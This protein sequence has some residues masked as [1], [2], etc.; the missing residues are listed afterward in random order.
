[1]VSNLNL[2]DLDG[3]SR[4]DRIETMLRSSSEQG[5]GSHLAPVPAMCFGPTVDRAVSKEP[6]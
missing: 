6:A 4:R 2:P 3:Q 1:M 5:V